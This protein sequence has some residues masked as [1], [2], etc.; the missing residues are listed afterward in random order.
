MDEPDDKNRRE[1]LE[2]RERL[3]DELADIL[4]DLLLQ[5]LK[6]PPGQSASPAAS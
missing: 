1:A 6:Q 4:A 5:D 3:R 2:A